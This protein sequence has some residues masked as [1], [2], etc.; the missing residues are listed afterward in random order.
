MGEEKG[1]AARG[2]KAEWRKTKGRRRTTV[3]FLTFDLLK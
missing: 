2:G 3:V 1:G